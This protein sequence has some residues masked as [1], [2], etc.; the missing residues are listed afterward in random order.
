MEALGFHSIFSKKELSAM[1]V[2]FFNTTKIEQLYSL[3]EFHLDK[4]KPI[5][6]C[7]PYY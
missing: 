5:I 4:V 2:I 1:S 7:N 3:L 6:Q